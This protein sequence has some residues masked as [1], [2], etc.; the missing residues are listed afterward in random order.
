MRTMEELKS[1]AAGFEQNDLLAM[2]NIKEFE[3]MMREPGPV[4]PSGARILW[5]PS[6]RFTDSWSSIW[7][8]PT[9]EALLG[10]I[11]S[12]RNGLWS[13]SRSVKHETLAA[14]KAAMDE[15]MRDIH[16]PTESPAAA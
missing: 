5:K 6:G 1:I 3:S 11:V 13:D 10:A 14:A 7:V 9:G 12:H 15:W 8:T 2:L 4:E 16:K